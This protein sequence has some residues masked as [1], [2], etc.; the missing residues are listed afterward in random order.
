MDASSVDSSVTHGH[1]A[2][3]PAPTDSG[4]PGELEDGQMAGSGASKTKKIDSA[5]G[6][7]QLGDAVLTVPAGALTKS[8]TITVTESK[9]P[10]PTG[11]TAYSPLYVFEPDGTM[12]QKPVTVELPYK[13]E[14]KLATLFWSRPKTDGTGWER[15]GGVPDGDKVHAEVMHFSSGF[16]ADGIDYTEQPDRSCAITRVLDMRPGLPRG[17]S[18]YFACD[19]LPS[20]QSS[21]SVSDVPVRVI[22]LCDPQSGCGACANGAFEC[23]SGGATIPLSKVCDG[24]PDCPTHD[25]LDG[26]IVMTPDETPCMAS[27]YDTKAGLPTGGVAMFFSMEDCWGRP[28]TDVK[29]SNISVLEDD[30]QI[31]VEGQSKVSRGAHI[32]LFATLLLDVSKST[33]SVLDQVIDG[34]KA[35]V[36]R[37]DTVTS[38]NSGSDLRVQ[39]AIEL[40][41]GRPDVEVWQSHTLDLAAV[42]KRLDSLAKYPTGATGTPDSAATNLNGGIIGSLA[43]LNRAQTAFRARNHG[44]ALSNSYLVLFT[45]GRDTAGLVPHSDALSAVRSDTTDVFVVGLA[46]SADFDEQALRDFAPNALVSTTSAQTLTREFGNVAARMARQVEATYRLNYCSPKRKDE[47]SVSVQLDGAKNQQT[48]VD[49]YFDAS[50]FGPGCELDAFDASCGNGT[51]CGGLGCGACDDRVSECDEASRTCTSLCIDAQTC[52]GSKVTNKRGYSQTCPATDTF[53]ECVNSCIDSTSDSQNCGACGV[54]CGTHGHCMAGQCVSDEQVCKC[55]GGICGLPPPSCPGPLCIDGGPMQGTEVCTDNV[56]CTLCRGE[57]QTSFPKDYTYVD[58]VTNGYP[59]W[60]MPGTAGHARSYQQTTDTV[61]DDVTGLEWQA[62]FNSALQTW[63]NAS[64][65]CEDLDLAGHTDWRLPMRIEL[66]STFDYDSGQS[67]LS[68]SSSPAQAFWTLSTYTNTDHVAVDVRNGQLSTGDENANF[69]TRCV[70]GGTLAAQDQHLSPNT[71]GMV[72]DQQTGLAWQREPSE[73][74]YVEADAHAYC[75]ALSL[76]GHSDWRLPTVSELQTLISETN[77]GHLDPNFTLS[78]HAPVRFWTT[79]ALPDA[80]AV[81]W[82]VDFDGG[83]PFTLSTTGDGNP[84]GALCVR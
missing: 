6:T 1:D 50:D 2:G 12:F 24:V 53:Y 39:L 57:C 56:P 60:P 13:G 55:V 36:E 51:E 26:G 31:S 14:Q 70:R 35:F 77:S 21:D 7:L 44:G 19:K 3:P 65:Y 72:T 73:Q 54:R 78:E 10:T 42:T 45:D 52:D 38:S 47:H 74:T 48:G 63:G 33:Q 28:I 83:T 15:L 34:A 5:G 29:D 16:I 41:D 61:I 62:D 76:G 30:T 23:T 49:A 27:P 75:A 84:I 68:L 43:G 18:A 81:V 20:N 17:P 80:Q 69:V 67:A 59:S 58:C 82:A 79:T 71:N 46:G 66:V 32:E 4:T 11:Y 9:T 25:P 37:V 22:D 40:F 8:T 64:F